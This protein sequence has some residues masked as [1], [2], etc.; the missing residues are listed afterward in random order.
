MNFLLPS[1][2]WAESLSSQL[3]FY[4]WLYNFCQQNLFMNTI[5]NR[6]FLPIQTIYFCNYFCKNIFKCV[7]EENVHI[8][9]SRCRKVV[10]YTKFIILLSLLCL[11]N[12][13]SC[14]HIN[15]RKRR[16]YQLC[17]HSISHSLL[18]LDYGHA[19]VICDMCS[20]ICYAQILALRNWY[21]NDY[22]WFVF[23]WSIA[24]MQYQ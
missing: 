14:L 6:L 4:P 21:C 18:T 13:K 15:V 20:C 9:I 3:T 2:K 5:R 23:L 7:I 1:K 8:K 24:I 22:T 16:F 19:M 17:I 11:Q 12:N 10:L